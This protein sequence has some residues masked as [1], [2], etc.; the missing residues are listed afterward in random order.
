MFRFSPDPCSD[1][2]QQGQRP[3]AGCLSEAVVLWES[4]ARP[5]PRSSDLCDESPW[6]HLGT[7]GAS[8]RGRRSNWVKYRA[9][10]NDAG[11]YSGILAPRHHRSG[12]VVTSD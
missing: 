10:L 2:E 9:V 4:Q 3:E 12:V 5:L 6:L 8:R 11:E 7:G 1:W